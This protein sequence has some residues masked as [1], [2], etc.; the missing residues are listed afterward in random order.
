MEKDFNLKVLNIIAGSKYGGAEIFFERLAESFQKEKNIKQ[1]VILRSSS[2]RFSNLKAVIPDIEQIKIF[3]NFNLFCHFKIESII[4]KFS[5]HIILTWMNRASKLLPYKKYRNEIRVGRLGGYY[6]IKNY[7]KCDYLITNTLDI[8]NYV[9]S[10]G[11]DTK[12]VEF[13]PNFV[14]ENTNLISQK[15]N[16][17]KLLCMGRFHHNKAFDTLIKA[18]SFLPT[19]ELAIVGNGELKS[20]YEVL[21]RKYKLSD[22]VKIHDWTSNISEFMNKSSILVCPSRHEPFGNIIVE[23]WA[24]KIPVI[25]S[26]TGGPAKM[27]KHKYNGM[28]FEKDNVFDLASKIKEIE[29]NII[30]KKKLIKNGFNSFKM[31]YSEDIIVKKYISFFKK[32]RRI[33]AE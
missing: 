9:I 10:Q 26:N 33:C 15:A 19:Y 22:R 14:N 4:K 16:N 3:N 30:L 23:G 8:K 11:W 31:N 20:L 28:K 2:N 32:I 24:H 25:V 18:M 13:I 12:K 17:I 1:K 21:I 7:L 5:P 29:S 6:K 27:I